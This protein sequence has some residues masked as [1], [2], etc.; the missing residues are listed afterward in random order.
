MGLFDKLKDAITNIA[1]ESSEKINKALDDI[2][3]SA[4]SEVEKAKSGEKVPDK[5]LRFPQFESTI[6]ELSTK[7]TDKYERCTIDYY[8][9]NEDEINTYIDKVIQ[10]GYIKITDVRYEKGNDYIIIEN[11]N[12]SLHLV[13]HCRF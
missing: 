5:Y 7:K 8:K 3:S 2:Y 1:P 6:G 11:G 4:K 12:T 13:F 10:D 9:T